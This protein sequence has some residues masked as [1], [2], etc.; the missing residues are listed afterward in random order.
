MFWIDL[1]VCDDDG[2]TPI[3]YRHRRTWSQ[4]FLRK[5]IVHGFHKAVSKYSSVYL[6]P[7]INDFT[8]LNPCLDKNDI[9]ALK[10]QRQA[11]HCFPDT[12]FFRVGVFVRTLCKFLIGHIPQF[13][14]ILN[15]ERIVS[16]CRPTP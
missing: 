10:I 1:W 2:D 9:L 15:N 16:G 6:S 5:Y 3:Y 13:D 12:R 4:K 8:P 7:N 14:E 11:K